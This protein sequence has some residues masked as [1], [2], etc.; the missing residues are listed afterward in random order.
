[1]IEI[2]ITDNSIVIEGHTNTGEYGGDIVC[3]S[4]STILQ[5]AQLGLIQLANQYPEYIDLTEV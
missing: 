3:A 4:V 5:V 2:L 1:M